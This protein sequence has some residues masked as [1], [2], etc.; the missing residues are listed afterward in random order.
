[1]GAHDS[2]QIWQVLKVLP[3]DKALHDKEFNKFGPKIIMG[4]CI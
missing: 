1:M 4:S 2:C 3:Y